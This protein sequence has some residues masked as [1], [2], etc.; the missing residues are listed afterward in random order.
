MNPTSSSPWMLILKADPDRYI[1]KPAPTLVALL[2]VPEGIIALTWCFQMIHCIQELIGGRLF[3]PVGLLASLLPRELGRLIPVSDIAF[4][5]KLDMIACCAAALCILTEL[6]CMAAEAAG[7]V[8]LRF[9]APEIGAKCL[10]ITRRCTL[11]ACA[12]LTGCVV[13]FCVPQILSLYNNGF[14]NGFSMDFSALLP[15][16]TQLAAVLLLFVRIVYH[17]GAAVVMTAVDYEYTLGFKETGMGKTRLGLASFLLGVIFLAA[18]V[19]LYLHDAAMMR[20]ALVLLAVSVKFF[21]VMK[22]FR[23]FQRCHR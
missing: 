2:K 9:A 11:V 20:H 23:I 10:K 3:S 1:K 16:I 5:T 13:L 17:R 4:G 18:A 14:S 12:A 15:L 21:A 6:V 19:L 22:S 7:A 8:L